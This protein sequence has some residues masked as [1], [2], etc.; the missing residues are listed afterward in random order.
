MLCQHPE[1]SPESLLDEVA[2]VAKTIGNRAMQ[3]VLHECTQQVRANLLM[4]A[5]SCLP[6]EVYSNESILLA[7]APDQDQLIFSD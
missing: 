2:L 5:L 1:L 7:I 4:A 3:R 6:S